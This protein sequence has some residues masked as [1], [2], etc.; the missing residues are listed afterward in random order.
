MAPRGRTMCDVEKIIQGPK[1]FQEGSGKIFWV[2]SLSCRERGGI[3]QRGSA[4]LP[5]P[6]MRPT[7]APLAANRPAPAG[8]NVTDV[9]F[10]YRPYFVCSMRAGGTFESRLLLRSK[11]YV[12]AI[13]YGQHWSDCE[14]VGTVLQRRR[15][16]FAG[17]SQEPDGTKAAPGCNPRPGPLFFFRRT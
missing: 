2:I 16:V 12:L 11:T 7:L 8:V 1:R 17:W 10:G 4:S 14:P 3:N 6:R 13:K 5:I 15:W 9:Q